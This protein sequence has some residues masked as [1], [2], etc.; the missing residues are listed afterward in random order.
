MNLL[1]RRLLALPSGNASNGG[2][3]MLPGDPQVERNPGRRDGGG[4]RR[5]RWKSAARDP[6]A[7]VS[8]RLPATP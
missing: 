2:F 3:E 8:D 7:S 6:L 1:R 5:R 4:C